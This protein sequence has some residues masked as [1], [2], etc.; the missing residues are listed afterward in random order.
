MFCY[1]C[2]QT[3]R[4]NGNQGCTVIGNCGKDEK[5]ANLQDLLI[6]AVQG[7]AP[8]ALECNQIGIKTPEVDEFVAKAIFAT[9]T[10]V[11]FDAE[12]IIGYTRQAIIYREDL[13]SQYQAYC[14]EN[15][16]PVTEFNSEVVNFK[17]MSSDIAIQGQAD[18]GIGSFDNLFLTVGEDVAGLYGL[19]VFGLKGIA[20]YT[21]H[22]FELGYTNPEIYT[23]IYQCLA[24]LSEQ[25]SDAGKYLE[26]ATKLGETNYW[27]LELLDKATTETYGHP[28]PTQARITPVAGK[29]ILVSGHG[30]NDLKD[31]LDQTMGTGINV[32]THGETLPA[33]ALPELKKYPHLIGNYGGA[34]QEQQTEFAEFPGAILMTTN[35]LIAPQPAYANRIF[36][37]GTVGWSHIPHIQNRDFSPVIEAALAAPGFSTTPEAQYI[38]IGFARNTVL[39][40]ADK[41]ID[42][43]KTGAVKHFFLIGGCDGAKSGRNYYTDFAMGVPD[44]CMILTLGCG[45]Y[46]FNKHDFG[47]IGGLP[48]LLDMGQCN[49]SY[50][51]IQVAVALAQAFNCG[52]NELPLSLIISWFEQKAV[53]VLLTLLYLGI[54]NIHLGPTLPAFLTPATIDILVEKF[55]IR[56]ISTAEEDLHR[57]LN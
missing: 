56:P 34:W 49:D 35:C 10:N 12:R 14:R 37:M 8:Y 24:F 1:Q 48:R 39:G 28:E 46:R 42:A 32:Y 17:L 53:A 18:S 23:R 43:V 21:D 3:V 11:N 2:E 16:Q 22:S 55:K 40:V 4:D 33:L 44:D 26:W 13:K 31:L 45:K 41:V 30:L 51:A 15:N 54:E 27:A 25:S 36:T 6:F 5:T 20:A 52:V 19:I 7:I 29:A 50:S 57:I 47:T 38:P 9:L